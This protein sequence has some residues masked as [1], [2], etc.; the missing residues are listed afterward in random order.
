MEVLKENYKKLGFKSMVDVFIEDVFSCYNK[1]HLVIARAGASTLAEL[2]LCSKAAILIPYPF[3]AG[4]HQ[5]M[6]A[7]VFVDRGAALMIRSHEL[8]GSHLS[9]E[10]IALEKDRKRLQQMESRAKTLAK[11]NASETIVDVCCQM[12]AK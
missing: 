2:A 1:A 8:S 11:P 5:E 9:S 7:N 10:I 4:N 3:A 12:A 6:N